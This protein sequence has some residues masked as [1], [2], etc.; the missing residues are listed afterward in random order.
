[1]KTF[2]LVLVGLM[3]MPMAAGAYETDVEVDGVRYA[4]NTTT[5][6][7]A[8]VSNSYTGDV[9]IRPSVTYDYDGTVCSVTSIWPV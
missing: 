3:S 5:K 4:I 9:V 8:V 6:T 1:M 2:L 7:A